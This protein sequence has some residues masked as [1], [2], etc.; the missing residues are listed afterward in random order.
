MTAGGGAK[1]SS[2]MQRE[3]KMATVSQRSPLGGLVAGLLGVSMAAMPVAP[4]MACS[5]IVLQGKGGRSVSARTVDFE[6][7]LQQRFVL[8]G[9]NQAWQSNAPGNARGVSWRNKLGFVGAN[10]LDEI[11]NM[12]DGINEAG[13]GV[14]ILWIDE[15]DYPTPTNPATA[16]SVLDLAAYVLGQFRNVGEVK[17]ALAKVTVWGEFSAEIKEVLPAHLVVHDA[18]GAS[19][20]FEWIGGTLRVYDRDYAGVMTNDPA[21]PVQLARISHRSGCI[22]P[23]NLR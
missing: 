13:L 18:D 12:F 7:D 9:R 4:A 14:G 15:A 3:A 5:D 20:V 2:G 17:A 1:T 10:T 16:L 21:Y 19:A 8:V 11:D 6:V 23:R 22:G